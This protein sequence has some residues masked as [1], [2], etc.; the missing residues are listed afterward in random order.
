LDGGGHRLH[1]RQQLVGGAN[2]MSN[3]L[4]QL[5]SDNRPLATERTVYVKAGQD[6][7]VEARV[8]AG[9]TAWNHSGIQSRPIFSTS[10]ED[11]GAKGLER[12]FGSS[13]RPPV[14]LHFDIDPL[15]PRVVAAAGQAFSQQT[16][17]ADGGPSNDIVIDPQR[18]FDVLGE[19]VIPHQIG[20]AFFKMEHE[21]QRCDF[22]ERNLVAN[23]ADVK[24]VGEYQY[25]MRGIAFGPYDEKSVMHYPRFTRDGRDAGTGSPMPT[26]TDLRAARFLVNE[27]RIQGALTA[28]ILQLQAEYEG[29]G[30]EIPSAKKQR[31]QLILALQ[32][33]QLRQRARI[34]DMKATQA[35][36][37][38][39]S[40]LK[41]TQNAVAD[42]R[43]HLQ[44]LVS[45]YKDTQGM[46]ASN[47]ALAAADDELFG[48]SQGL[49]VLPG[50]ATPDH[51][52]NLRV[53]P[54]DK[55]FANL[56]VF[57]C[58]SRFFSE[59]VKCRVVG[60]RVQNAESAIASIRLETGNNTNA[61]YLNV[62]G[63]VFVQV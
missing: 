11:A 32:S 62:N 49:I 25:Q 51:P 29:P 45:K 60:L 40:V 36:G 43:Q 47:L 6:S 12:I 1:V 20:H 48:W 30:M 9:V 50:R 55:V 63:R 23:P 24:A 39:T 4:D 14:D 15:S 27:A 19:T 17:N 8:A 16:T 33:E 41:S 44:Y 10:R 56:P 31:E 35:D 34:Q 28:M 21:H 54:H 18:E 61:S 52:V 58:E 42:Q 7:K 2:F 57:C 38:S 22:K 13:I 59:L 37:K 3:F 5:P 53:D 46:V 26:Q